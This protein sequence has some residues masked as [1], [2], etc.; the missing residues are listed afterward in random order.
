MAASRITRE[1]AQALLDGITRSGEGWWMTA[2]AAISMGA[3][4]ALGL[5]R[6][7]FIQ[8]IGQRLIDSH[9][10]I[11]QLHQ[12]GHSQQAIADILR[13]SPITVNR[14]LAEEGLIDA[15]PSLPPAG[16]RKGR[17]SSPEH[18]SAD[19]PVPPEHDSADAVD[20]TAVDL[21]AE[22]KRLEGEVEARRW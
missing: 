20:T 1:D 13:V 7:G 6:R 9:E 14:T 3:P 18:D 17:T 12:D 8:A 11:V 5:D 21:D 4:K 2:G 15:R 16:Q 10:A 22:V 19:E